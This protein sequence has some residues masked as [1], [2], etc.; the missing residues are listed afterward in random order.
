VQ[1]RKLKVYKYPGLKCSLSL[2]A[3]LL[4]ENGVGLE[5]C[6]FGYP[7]TAVGEVVFTTSHTGYT[8][9]LTDPSYKG[10][11]LVTTHPMVGNYGV[12]ARTAHI[13]RV[14]EDYESGEIQAEGYIV[15]SLPLPN[16]YASV[17]SLHSW[18]ASEEKPGLYSVDTRFLVK[19]IREKGVMM[20]VLSTYP[21]SSDPPSWDELYRKLSST[22]SYGEVPLAYKVSPRKPVIHRPLGLPKASVGVLDCGLKHGIL[23]NLLALG[24]E[25]TRYPCTSKPDQIIEAHDA[26]VV[27][28]GPG[29]PS[30]LVDAIQS[31]GEIAVS[32]KPVLGICLGM[33]LIALGLGGES[34]K[35]PYGHRAVNKPVVENGSGRCFITTHNHGYAID[36]GFLGEAGLSV[37]FTQPD[38]GTLEGFKSR[39]GNVL[40]VQFHPEGG[41]GPWDTTW[42]FKVFASRIRGWSSVG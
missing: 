23:R 17:S 30:L 36:A 29:N 6:G 18:M 4:L 39:D 15:S 25:V 42:I 21:E 13:P 8:E 9:S 10:Q 16:H 5:G 2:K 22:P 32:G 38:D 33:Q 14:L 1:G 26:V 20:G 24:L 35:L 41:P 12:P 28:N 34:Y 40:A 11:I 3:R 27:S 19:L 7:T 31:A 37:W